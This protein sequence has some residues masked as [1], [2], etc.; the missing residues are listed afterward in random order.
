MNIEILKEM[1]AFFASPPKIEM[2]EEKWI[3]I[4]GLLTINQEDAQTYLLDISVY[5][6]ATRYE[7]EDYDYATIAKSTNFTEICREAV[8]AYL[9][10]QIDALLENK[11]C[12]QMYQEYV[13]D[14]E[15]AKKYYK[16]YEDHW[17]D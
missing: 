1:F 10:V 6:A 11:A 3:S 16:M 7:P 13:A 5:R 8:K 14:Q 4:D 15:L 17:E 9:N 12:D 2:S